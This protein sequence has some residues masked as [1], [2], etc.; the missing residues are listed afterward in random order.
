MERVFSGVETCNVIII[1][2]NLFSDFT[3]FDVLLVRLGRQGRGIA[4]LVRRCVS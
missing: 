1:W 3:G 2:H 4:A